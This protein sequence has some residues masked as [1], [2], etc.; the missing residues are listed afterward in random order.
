M[1]FNDIISIDQ[2]IPMVTDLYARVHEN[3]IGAIVLLVL[4]LLCCFAGFRLAK[5]VFAVGGALIGAGLCAYVA[6][7]YLP[8]PAVQIGSIA[9]AVIGAILVAYLFYHL[10][11]VAVFVCC[12]AVGA[13]VGSVPAAAAGLNA[14]ESPAFLAAIAVCAILFGVAGILFIK[15]VLI[16]ITGLGGMLAAPQIFVLAHVN[17][18]LKMELLAGAVLSVIG[19]AVQILTNR[20][21]S[22]PGFK[23]EKSKTEPSDPAAPV[24][25]Y[26]EIDETPAAPV[27][28]ADGL[29]EM[30]RKNVGTRFLMAVSPLLAVVAAAAAIAG[31]VLFHSLHIE[32]ALIF[33]FFCFA[34]RH[35]KSLELSYVLMLV[36]CGMQAVTKYLA[37]DG[38]TEVL[39]D[40]II[41]VTAAVILLLL[42]LS[43]IVMDRRAHPKK[44]I[45]KVPIETP[46]AEAEDSLEATRPL[47]TEEIEN[48]VEVS[49]DVPENE[50]HL[51]EDELAQ[52]RTVP[53]VDAPE[54]ETHLMEDELAQT[55]TVPEMDVPE[56]E[57][58]LMEEA[59][60]AE[61]HLMEETDSGEDTDA[62]A[63]D[64]MAEEDLDDTRI[65]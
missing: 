39:V 17:Q 57:T 7:A 64:E 4:G 65:L 42:L 35:Y 40:M 44:V 38:S 21:R 52:T 25:Q 27:M 55:R 32:L 19:I 46:A 2:L 54:N 1:N 43:A 51:M 34:G 49:E 10:Y 53:E 58:R 45:R 16:V 59:D 28:S 3:Q 29:N 18:G 23:A 33:V 30:F 12:A 6:A 60:T 31:V 9:A 22:T 37:N 47:P 36:A 61:T 8:A 15:P 41:A 63:E 24:Q 20:K 13:A 48:A 5:F 56:N 50:T 62:P 11:M 14:G 26:E